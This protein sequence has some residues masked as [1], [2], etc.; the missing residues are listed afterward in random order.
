MAGLHSSALLKSLPQLCTTKVF[1]TLCRRF[2]FNVGFFFRH[3]LT[4]MLLYVGFFFFRP[5]LLTSFLLYVG[6]FQV[7]KLGD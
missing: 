7:F 3:V 1:A 5:V 4:S 2:V 6:V